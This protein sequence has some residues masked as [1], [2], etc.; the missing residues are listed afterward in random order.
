MSDTPHIPLRYIS[1]GGVEDKNHS[2]PYY[3]TFNILT[4]YNFKTTAIN[5]ANVA[6]TNQSGR[7]GNVRYV[8][9]GGL[10]Y[11]RM[12]TTR[13]MKNPKSD[14]QM[15]IRLE[16]AS[17]VALAKKLNLKDCFI[18]SNP[19]Q[20]D[21]NLFHKKNYGVGCYFT[22]EQIENGM[23][24]MLPVQ[25]TQGDGS[26]D[27]IV[28]QEVQGGITSGLL[29]T[30]GSW[31]ATTTV[32]TASNNLLAANPLLR[33]GDKISCVIIN[34]SESAAPA[35][36][37]YR[38]KP[39]EVQSLVI[40]ESSDELLWGEGRVQ[41]FWSL[42]DNEQDPIFLGTTGSDGLFACAYVVSRNN[43]DGSVSRNTCSLILNSSAGA[44][45]DSLLDTPAFK[46]ACLS[47]GQP[48]SQPWIKPESI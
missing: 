6:V 42:I 12:A 39:M 18:K 25:I 38:I 46:A 41:K 26:L 44:A 3:L 30:N 9:K 37:I 14:A 16:M 20:S 31:T 45:L 1:A 43:P 33:E 27:E 29:V 4:M 47:Y 23:G 40:D 28:C 5:N 48:T 24:W 13:S 2:K 19:N 36:G 34:A 22:K 8:Q 15:K 17:R 21:I 32:G 10:T 7:I 11:V 35:D